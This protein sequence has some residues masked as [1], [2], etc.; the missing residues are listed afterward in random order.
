MRT[1]A[2]LLRSALR[3]AQVMRALR[4]PLLP[5]VCACAMFVA[6]AL[7]PRGGLLSHEPFVDVRYYATLSQRMLDG[8]VPYRDFFFDYPP[9]AVPVIA[10][11][12]WLSQ[13]HYQTLFKVEMLLIGIAAVAAAFWCLSLVGASRLRVWFAAAAIALSPLALGPVLLNG[14]DLW[15]TAL[16]LGAVGLLVAGSR[17]RSSALAGAGAAVKGFSVALLPLAV[18][19]RRWLR[20]A[21]AFVVAFAVVCLPAAVAGAG[22]L[23]Y[24]FRLQLERGLHSESLGGSLL[25]A[26]HRGR[27]ESRPPGSLDVIGGGAHALALVTTVLEIAAVLAVAYVATRAPQTRETMLRACAAAIVAFVAFGKAFSP[28]YL[29]WL[30]PLVPLVSVSGTVL[31]AV[32]AVLTQLWVLR[33]VTPFDPGGPAWVALLRNL[34]VVAIYVVLVRTLVR[35]ATARTTATAPAAH[36]AKKLGR[37]A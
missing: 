7:V 5:P 13:V 3:C 9:G 20:V 21:A 17:V 30:V 2:S 37:L 8:H 6:S 31:L 29:V 12:G 23:R 25:V 15:P 10:I 26:L 11:P 19:R 14:Y 33:V 24:S 34:L 22:G 35:T 4:Y 18:D 16:G 32:A 28:Q 27:L 1:A 36:S